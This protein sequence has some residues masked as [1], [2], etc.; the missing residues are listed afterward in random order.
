VAKASGVVEP[1]LLFDALSKG[2]ADSFALRNHGMKSL[3]PES[4]P[5]RAF[6]VSYMLKDVSYALELARDAGLDLQSAGTVKKLLEET[7]RLGQGEAYHTAIIEAV[8][9]HVT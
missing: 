1:K 2:S 6:P 3:L 7:V 5:E 4:H 8:R 9:K